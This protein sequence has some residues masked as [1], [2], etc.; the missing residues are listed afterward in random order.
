MILDGEHD[1]NMYINLS[2]NKIIIFLSF[3]LAVALMIFL[4]LQYKEK[5]PSDLS[6]MDAFG[7]KIVILSKSAYYSTKFWSFN[8]KLFAST[9]LAFN[10]SKHEDTG[11]NGVAASVPVLLYHGI[12]KTPDRF[13][14]T[15]DTFAEQ[16]LALKK[17][18]Y[19]AISLQD[20]SDFMQGKKDLSDKSVLIT[21]DDGR[22]DS[23]EGADPVMRALDFHAV[24]FVAT[25]DSLNS[26][27]APNSYYLDQSRIL[28]MI[29]SGRWSVG[30]HAVQK[31]TDAGE[32]RIDEQED[33]GNFL[34]NKRWL[35][36]Q[37]RIET[38][39]E[40][41][42]RILN[43][44]VTS[45]SDLEEKLSTNVEAMSYPFSDFGQQT[46]NN[47]NAINVISD[48]VKTTYKYAFQQVSLENDLPTDFMAN[49]RFSDKYHLHRIEVGTEWSGKYL[50]DMLNNA[51]DK[52]M[53]W[54][55]DFS[56]NRGWN[57]T[58]GSAYILSGDLDLK[59][60]PKTTGAFAF[61]DGSRNWTNYMF[62]ANIKVDNGSHVSLVSRYADKSNYVSCVF[63]TD[64]VRIEE[65]IDGA[66]TILTRVKNSVNASMQNITLGMLNDGSFVRCY[67]GDRVAAF[68]FKASPKL[69]TGGIGFQ[70]WNESP[71]TAHMQVD[72]VNVVPIDQS[73]DLKN[74]LPSY[75]I[76]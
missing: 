40:Y 14:M 59:A 29:Q 36:D 51:H 4:T 12:V 73:V 24:M 48:I 34:S 25:A 15:V 2:F 28:S 66:S 56:V 45:K 31:D 65:K 49:Y 19:T 43:E 22:A 21:F 33:R 54:N 60:T 74:K 38:D 61:L 52:S 32:I 53:S 67:E 68:T 72:N 10:T 16:M 13:S 57:P 3:C 55:D 8:T 6:S 62:A 11:S 69:S 47:P 17:A 41:K 63:S 23:Y 64:E 39:E 18:G 50:V 27:L 58:W 30:S 37:K 7:N 1:K 35:V 42:Q 76:R 71:S 5:I 20:F 44:L 70:I 75:G 26:R 46:Q 9:I